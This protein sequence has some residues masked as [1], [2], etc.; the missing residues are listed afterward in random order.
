MTRKSAIYN[1]A[2]E[3]DRECREAYQLYLEQYLTTV[4]AVT[5]GATVNPRGR[6]LGF[7]TVQLV[8]GPGH[9]MRRK[10]YATREL[11][12]HVAAHPVL[13]YAEFERQWLAARLGGAA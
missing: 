3:L 6:A 2:A 5:N 10:A 12:D 8:T 11:Q 13:T 7:H 4:E 1:H 9:H